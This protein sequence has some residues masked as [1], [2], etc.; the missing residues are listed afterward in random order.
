MTPQEETLITQLFARLKEAP[1]QPKEAEADRLI[2]RGIAE[3]PDAPYLLV[4]TV[5]I[6]DMALSQAQ[7]RIAELEKQLAEAGSRE[8]T[9]APQA[10]NFLN[11]TLGRGSVPASPWHGTS[12]ISSAAPPSSPVSGWNRGASGPPA[13]TMAA[14]P[15][16]G[17]GSGFLHAAA[18]TALGV[19]GGQL[20]FQGIESLFGHPAGAVFAGQPLQPA[21]SETVTNNYY[22]GDDR[23]SAADGAS[24]DSTLDSDKLARDD[25]AS[26]DANDTG[27][28]DSDTAWNDGFGSD[29]TDLV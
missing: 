6:Q 8:T 3:Q 24:G 21:I 14:G 29:D 27:L 26:H 5:L 7:Q 4:Q 10:T 22:G 19:A 2:S 18:A 20:V 16:P 28:D 25:D 13:G 12:P 11:R 1:A 9:P 17:A 15:M 23:Q